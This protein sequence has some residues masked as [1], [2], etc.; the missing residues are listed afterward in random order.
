MIEKYLPP[1]PSLNAFNAAAKRKA[2]KF[3]DYIS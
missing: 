3:N 1:P 2:L